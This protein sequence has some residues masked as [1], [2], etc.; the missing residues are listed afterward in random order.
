MIDEGER[1]NDRRD[2]ASASPEQQMA[3]GLES[4]GLTCVMTGDDL[5]RETTAY[6]HAQI[7]LT[8]AMGVEV[9]RY[10]GTELV[11]TAPLAL[12]HNHLGTAFGGS[13]NAIATLAGYVLLWL[14]LRDRSA[15]IV[16]RESRIQFRRP[17]KGGLRAIC[18]APGGA[19]LDEFHESFVRK[20]KARLEL[21]VEMFEDGELAVAFDG[22][23]VAVR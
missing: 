5:L 23:F 13:L 11:I 18:R 3:F 8:R 14:E 10:D 15:H 20:G 21:H 9:A 16:I 4:A 2:V 19:A 1:E 6:L 22:T 12:N 7:P 17:V